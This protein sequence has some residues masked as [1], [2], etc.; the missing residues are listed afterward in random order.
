MDEKDREW[1]TLATQEIAKV[2]QEIVVERTTNAD[3]PSQI[4]GKEN[5]NCAGDYQALWCSSYTRSGLGQEQREL[6]PIT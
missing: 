4:L 1:V 6:K 3:R 5:R 2:F